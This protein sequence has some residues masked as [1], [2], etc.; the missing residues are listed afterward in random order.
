[1]CTEEQLVALGEQKNEYSPKIAQLLGLNAAIYLDIINEIYGKATKKQALDPEGYCTL[2]RDYIQMQTTLTVD[3]QLNCDVVLEQMGIVD[4]NFL[5]SDSIK[6][7]KAKYGSI[8]FGTDIKA[9]QDDAKKTKV[10]REQQKENKK[11]FQA[12]GVKK[13]IIESDPDIKAKLCDLVDASFASKYRPLNKQSV[14]VFQDTIDR[15]TPDKN[16]KIKIIEIAISN[17][18]TDPSW[19]INAFERDFKRTGLYN[20]VQDNPS[21]VVVNKTVK[22]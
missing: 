5:N 22:F 9:L 20:R 7:D 2:D 12:V 16:V 14:K 11:I 10:G 15:Y 1:M 6:V 3:Q 17:G 13:T 8:L 19:A 18:Y 4:R 21:D